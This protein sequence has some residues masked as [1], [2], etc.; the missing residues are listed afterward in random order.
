M[1]V[2]A[3]CPSF[4][5]GWVRLKECD[6]TESDIYT[7]SDVT[8]HHDYTNSLE[9]SFQNTTELDAVLA[10]YMYLKMLPHS[11]KMTRCII[12]LQLNVI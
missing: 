8:S 4:V 2:L 10:M 3:V 12:E 9:L 1:S 7:I 11:H 6:A 5:S